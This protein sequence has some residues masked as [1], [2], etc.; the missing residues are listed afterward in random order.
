MRF[1]S[2]CRRQRGVSLLEMLSTITIMG[3]VSAVALPQLMQMPAAARESVVM[4]LE[5]AVRSASALMHVTCA[6]RAAV[7]QL[8]AA[9]AALPLQG[10]ALRMRHGYP[11]G[12]EPDG[13]LQALELTGFTA[14]H[15]ADT[16]VF[17]KVGAPRAQ[18]C[19][20]SYRS[21]PQSG[22]MPLIQL[23]TSGC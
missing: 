7:C 10:G 11:Q 22:A 8:D 15:T 5:G 12:G 4:S 16:T 20:V 6:A 18:A 19:A 13:I 17:Q 21:A 23:E 9:Q 1:T 2:F 3:S 14:V